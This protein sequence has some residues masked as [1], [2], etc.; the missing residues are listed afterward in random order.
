MKL[1]ILL[2]KNG[3][4]WT[5]MES[6]NDFNENI[7][8]ITEIYEAIMYFGDK[9]H[10]EELNNRLTHIIEKMEWIVSIASNHEDRTH[11]GKYD[12]HY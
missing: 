8:E 12:E 5:L 9:T 11:K 6:T 3:W 7:E 10:L 4:T 1:S 2:L